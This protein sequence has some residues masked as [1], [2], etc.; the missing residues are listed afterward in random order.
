[1]SF[2]WVLLLVL[3][4]DEGPV[5]PDAGVEPVPAAALAPDAGPAPDPFHAE[6]TAK[7]GEGVTFKSGEVK[8]NLRGRV[9]VQALSVFPT[10]GSTAVRQNA[11]FVRRARLALKGEFPWHLSLNLQLAFALLDMEPDAPNV[12]RDFNIQWAPLRE[13][14]RPIDRVAPPARRTG[15][16]TSTTRTRRATCT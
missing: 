3:Q 4:A 12:L 10:E 6:V 2:A 5:T 9:Q 11:I 8:L 13:T 1:M 15:S 14:S 7:F 16:P